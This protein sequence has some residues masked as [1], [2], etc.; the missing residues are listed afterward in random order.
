MPFFISNA[1]FWNIYLKILLKIYGWYINI[2]AI[3][4]FK[5][6]ESTKKIKIIKINKTWCKEYGIKPLNY[7]LIIQHFILL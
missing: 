7:A 5:I 1:I 4:P 3:T 6:C 2:T